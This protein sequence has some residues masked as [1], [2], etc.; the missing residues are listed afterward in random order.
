MHEASGLAG[1]RVPPPRRV[2]GAQGS[3]PLWSLALREEENFFKTCNFCGFPF[4]I[5]AHG[6]A[7]YCRSGLNVEKLKI[8]KIFK[9][10]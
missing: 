6:R 7:Y 2:S 10:V 3:S 9:H 1:A 4:A 5:F 8:I